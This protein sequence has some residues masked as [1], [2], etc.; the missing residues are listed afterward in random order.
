MDICVRSAF[1]GTFAGLI[2]EE[3]LEAGEL[4]GGGG[5]FDGADGDFLNLGVG[6]FGLGEEGVEA[7]GLVVDGLFEG[8]DAGGEDVFFAGVIAFEEFFAGGGFLGEAGGGV[9]DG[10]G[11]GGV[12]VFGEGFGFGAE[13]GEFLFARGERLFALGE[14]LFEGSLFLGK[15]LFLFGGLI[16]KGV[17][18]LLL[19]AREGIEVFGFFALAALGFGGIAFLDVGLALFAFLLPEGACLLNFL[20]EVFALGG[21]LGFEGGLFIFMSLEESGKGGGGALD[22]VDFLEFLF[23][24]GD[25]ALELHIAGD[26]FFEAIGHGREGFGDG[27]FELADGFDDAA[28]GDFFGDRDG[29]G[30]GPGFGFFIGAGGGFTAFGDARFGFGEGV[31]HLLA[32]CAFFGGG[33]FGHGRAPVCGM[34]MEGKIRRRGAGGK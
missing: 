9:F 15:L 19:L 4:F 13:G 2:G 8:G 14:I 11:D 20:L 18:G 16:G 34:W 26:L 17:T 28:G 10:A 7:L 23:F 12:E 1:G 5:A 25:G 30:D 31:E 29:G 3:L 21:Q 27:G 24:G 32:G 22:V 33:F 6:F